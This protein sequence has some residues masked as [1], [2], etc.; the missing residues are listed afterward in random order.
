MFAAQLAGSVTT[1]CSR[2]I[3]TNRSGRMFPHHDYAV[4]LIFPDGEEQFN[5]CTGEVTV[6]DLRIDTPME[7]TAHVPVLEDD[8]GYQHRVTSK[9]RIKDY[10]KAVGRLHFTPE[11]ECSDQ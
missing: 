10:L 3:S 9:T 6:Y 7:G 11:S 4:T 5:T 2:P 8:T 1:Q